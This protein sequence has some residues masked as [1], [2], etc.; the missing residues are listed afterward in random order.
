[1]TGWGGERVGMPPPS[2]GIRWGGGAR[3]NSAWGRGGVAA[4]G[5]VEGALAY[6]LEGIALVVVLALE[7]G[8]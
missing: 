3:G 8:V 7:V 6:L 2:R 1:M 4:R 5:R